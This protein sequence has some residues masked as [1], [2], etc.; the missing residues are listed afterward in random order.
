LGQQYDS[1]EAFE[2]AN[3]SIFHHKS[4]EVGEEG[5]RA[6]DEKAKRGEKWRSVLLFIGIGKLGG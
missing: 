4:L 3:N 1:V 6:K 5:L 2:K